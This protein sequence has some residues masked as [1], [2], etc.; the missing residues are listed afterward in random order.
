MQR[1]AA[2]RPRRI[3]DR[4]DIEIG[5]RA[6]SGKRMGFGA[7]AGMGRSGVIP[8]EHR[9]GRDAPLPGGPGDTQGDLAAVCDQQLAEHRPSLARRPVAASAPPSGMRGISA[10]ATKPPPQTLARRRWS[11]DAGISAGTSKKKPPPRR[12]LEF[13]AHRV[14]SL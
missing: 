5:R 12:G 7:E 9:D 6:A 2:V 3:D 11:F 4:G 13:V 10:M 1:V 14:A 8:R